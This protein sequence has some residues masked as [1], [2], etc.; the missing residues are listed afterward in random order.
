MSTKDSLD[1]LCSI[2]FASKRERP[3]RNTHPQ[4]Q[5]QNSYQQKDT[6]FITRELVY[7]VHLSDDVKNI[8]QNSV[9]IAQPD[10]LYY[11]MPE[12]GISRERLEK[13]SKLL[14]AIDNFF[15][16]I[17][18]F[19]CG[20]YAS[21]QKQ[22]VGI[23]FTSENGGK[24]PYKTRADHVD[25][26]PV[27]IDML[28]ALASAY[29]PK[30]NLYFAYALNN[31]KEIQTLSEELDKADKILGQMQEHW[32]HVKGGMSQEELEKLNEEARKLREEMIREW[33]EKE[34]PN[35]EVKTPPKEKEIIMV[36]SKVEEIIHVVIEESTTPRWS[37]PGDR[38]G[39]YLYYPGDTIY[40]ET[41]LFKNFGNYK[42]EKKY[43]PARDS[44]K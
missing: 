13:E 2:G 3:V 29:G 22:K 8:V 40:V 1:Y 14:N 11:N 24:N 38:E 25:R 39:G 20:G 33:K 15:S 10:K 9:H 30:D 21:D 17:Y 32:E 28:L 31:L 19:L 36:D 27:N 26:Y 4:Y 44:I 37:A 23:V 5:N 6:T 34:N 42:I 7:E 16:N 12:H 18:N 41:K 35:K 43:Y